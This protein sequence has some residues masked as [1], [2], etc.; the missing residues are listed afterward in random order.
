MAI[1]ATEKAGALLR[2]IIFCLSLLSLFLGGAK[3]TWACSAC[4]GFGSDIYVQVRLNVEEG[5]LKTLHVQWLF[6]E[7]F[8]RTLFL[9]YDNDHNGELDAEERQAMSEVFEGLKPLDYLSTLMVNGE[10]LRPSVENLLF[11]WDETQAAI[12]FSIPCD[13]AVEDK[14]SLALQFSDPNG[15]LMFYFFPESLIWTPSDLYRISSDSNP[16]PQILQVTIQHKDSVSEGTF[17]VAPVSVSDKVMRWFSGLLQQLHT[18]LHSQLLSIK[19]DASIA[20]GVLFVF[21][22][23]LYGFVHAAGPGHG[24]S[25]VASYFLAQRRGT[26]KAITMA[27]SIGA[28]H[29]FS[30][31]LLT[32]VVLGV[33]KLVFSTAFQDA[34]LV[35]TRLSG[36]L[37]VLTALYLALVKFKATFSCSRDEA[38]L[39]SSPGLG[40]VPAC[41]CSACRVNNS[42]DLFVVLSAGIIPCPGTVTV[43]LFAI[44]MQLY[45]IGFLAAL[46]MSIG[47]GVVVFIAAWITIRSRDAISS[48]FKFLTRTVEYGSVGVILVLGVLLL[49]VDVK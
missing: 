35:L 2:K 32:I 5:R 24:K 10:V 16:Y 49:T 48:K 23:L 25:L 13:L 26:R 43:F 4:A 42:A 46:A 11:K 6:S 40:M 31:F 41:R 19:T 14:L 9:E 37:I 3:Q 44:S 18:R 33:L 15:Y 47:M 20:S 30:A 22:A 36:I 17:P 27:F 7:A 12:S 21:F 45:L 39:L 8:T 29:V 28:V 38:Q 34:T 1:S